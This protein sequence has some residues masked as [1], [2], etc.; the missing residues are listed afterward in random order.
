M[1]VKILVY[2]VKKEQQLSNNGMTWVL[3][4]GTRESLALQY[5]RYMLSGPLSEIF[6]AL[7]SHADVRQ[8]NL[9]FNRN[10]K[11][12]LFREERCLSVMHRTC[13]GRRYSW[14]NSDK[15]ASGDIVSVHAWTK[16]TAILIFMHSLVFF[17]SCSLVKI[18]F[19][20]SKCYGQ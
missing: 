19:S 4:S 13:L 7:P 14:Q 8:W 20:L 2:F 10:R 9:Q 5:T 11:R 12:M 3:L 18:F 1:N 15:S 17:N 16:S 6:G